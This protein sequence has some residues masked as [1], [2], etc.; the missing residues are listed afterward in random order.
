MINY[1]Y[2]NCSHLALPKI[3][4]G[5]QNTISVYYYG[6]FLY[7]IM[8]SNNEEYYY[9]SKVHYVGLLSMH[10]DNDWL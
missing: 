6:C 2:G 5:M 4:D 10:Y 8:L 9:V 1:Y 7:I 3:V